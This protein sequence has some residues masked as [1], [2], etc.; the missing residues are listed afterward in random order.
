MY[1]WEV[2]DDYIGW[3]TYGTIVGPKGDPGEKGDKGDPGKDGAPG[4]K[5]EPGSGMEFTETFYTTGGSNLRIRKFA[6]GM[7]SLYGTVST[8]STVSGGYRLA[9]LPDLAKP[10]INTPMSIAV[11]SSSATYGEWLISINGNDMTNRSSSFSSG[12]TL[13]FIGQT[14]QGA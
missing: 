10:A 9:Y 11:V 14:Y 5:G 1:I 4:E 6:D 3:V 12:N 2:Q 7:V 8:S 13:H